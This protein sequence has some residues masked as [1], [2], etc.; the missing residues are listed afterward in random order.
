[1]REANSP[2]GGTMRIR[3]TFALIALWVPGATL[4]A[5]ASTNKSSE[6]S[7][8]LR[9]GTLGIGVEANRLLNDNFGV[10]VGANYFSL[11]RTQTKENVSYDA[12]VKLQAFTG[13]VD[14]YPS[15]RGAFHL[16][17]G[18]ISDPVKFTGIGQPTSSGNITINN[19][20]YTTAQVG[21][22][23]ASIKYPSAS[24]YL[25]LGFGTPAAKKSGVGVVFDIGAAIGKPKVALSSTN[26]GSTAGLQ[27]NIDAQAAKMQKSADKLA[28]WPVISLGLTY[29]F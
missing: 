29:R 11:S 25:G 19:T 12:T 7:I 23:T 5:Q 15:K 22:L 17:A 24:P 6:T 27:A 18:V 3:N 16:S 2:I 28:L 20:P 26:A 8:G 13:L 14:W 9:F 1:M 10:R 4:A 21:S